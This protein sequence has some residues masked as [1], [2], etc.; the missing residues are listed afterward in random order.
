MLTFSQHPF[1]GF[2]VRLQRRSL[3]P[4]LHRL[5]NMLNRL[6]ENHLGVLWRVQFRRMEPDVFIL[7]TLL[8][9]LRNDF[10]GRYHFLRMHFERCRS[11]PSGSVLGIGLDD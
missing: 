1:L 9:P 8:A 6:C 10:P 4:Y 2:H 5:R 7:R 11:D 3:H